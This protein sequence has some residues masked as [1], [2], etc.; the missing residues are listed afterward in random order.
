MT[1][2]DPSGCLEPSSPGGHQLA[3]VTPDPAVKL[4]D[5][6]RPDTA[7]PRV[8]PSRLSLAQNEEF[9]VKSERQDV[10]VPGKAG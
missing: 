4:H 1:M 7:K 6:L 5:G 8:T 3:G 9:S 2:T 10:G